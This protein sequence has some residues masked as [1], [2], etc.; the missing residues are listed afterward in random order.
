[1]KPLEPCEE[2]MLT[3]LA[4][5]GATVDHFNPYYGLVVK[6]HGV[7]DAAWTA[8]DD[9]QPEDWWVTV[10]WE[11][12]RERKHPRNVLMSLSELPKGLKP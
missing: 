11:D 2:V 9:I 3:G 8:G 12:G 5:V 6:D 7:S 4:A 1:M 10:L